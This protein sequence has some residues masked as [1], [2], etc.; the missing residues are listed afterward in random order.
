LAGV[1]SPVMTVLAGG[2]V[3]LRPAADPV[4]LLLVH[5]PAYDDWSLPKGKV[6]EGEAVVAAALREVEEETGLHC[7]LGPELPSTRYRDRRGREKVVRY[8][9]MR[10]L[11]GFAAGHHEV[12]QVRWATPAEA[13]EL[14]TYDR[15]RRLLRAVAS[16]LGADW[17]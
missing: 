6:V 8:W 4:Q 16:R 10:P 5:R 12:D 2:G 3:V 17:C 14:L 15:D 9:V 11:F 1:A 7:E 13:I